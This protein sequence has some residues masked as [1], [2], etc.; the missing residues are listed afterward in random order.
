MRVFFYEKPSVPYRMPEIVM[1]VVKTVRIIKCHCTDTF[2]CP[3]LTMLLLS[4]LFTL[5][6]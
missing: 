5:P 1:N 6:V 4:R 3:S 2:K